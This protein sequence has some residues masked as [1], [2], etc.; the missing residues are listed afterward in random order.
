MDDIIDSN[1]LVNKLTLNFMI[2]KKQLYK[3]YKLHK[4]NTETKN[5]INLNEIKKYNERFKI[6]F[7]D[8]LVSQPPNNISLEV[9][10]AF[11]SFIEQSL[12]YFKCTDVRD[13]KIKD[14]DEIQDDIDFDKEERDIENGN[15]TEISNGHSTEDEDEDEDDN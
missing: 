5:Q 8:L 11:D 12:S 9:I 4:N 7:N 10:K 3:L 14:N 2:N 6:L 13:N 1:D 15:Y